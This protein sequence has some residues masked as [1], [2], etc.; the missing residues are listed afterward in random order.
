MRVGML[1]SCHKLITDDQRCLHWSTTCTAFWNDHFNGSTN[2]NTLK[3][4][5]QW[6]WRLEKAMT[7]LWLLFICLS[8]AHILSQRDDCI[9]FHLYFFFFQRLSV[10]SARQN[11][12]PSALSF[13][14]NGCIFVRALAWISIQ[15]ANAMPIIS[16]INCMQPLRPCLYRAA[17][18]YV[19]RYVRSLMCVSEQKKESNRSFN[20]RNFCTG[21]RQKI[22]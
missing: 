14:L 5:Q 16:I 8:A 9:S 4:Q 2:A 19:C 10:L 1:I 17:N 21:C 18:V 12:K 3:Y 15:V 13:R 7:F 22:E 11:E 6:R 20:K